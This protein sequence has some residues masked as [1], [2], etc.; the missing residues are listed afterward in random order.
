MAGTKQA[1]FLVFTVWDGQSRCNTNI[2]LELPAKTEVEARSKAETKWREIV[3]L[4][5]YTKQV[6]DSSSK[7]NYPH[8]PCIV[9]RKN[10]FS[11]G[12]Y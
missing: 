7:K 4:G 2:E 9:F 12:G 6:N 8:S 11:D 3:R 10:L 5:I 1:W